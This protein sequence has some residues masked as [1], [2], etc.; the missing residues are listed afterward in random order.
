MKDQSAFVCTD[1]DFRL[2]LSLAMALGGLLASLGW[3]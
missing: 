3:E 2:I 1:N